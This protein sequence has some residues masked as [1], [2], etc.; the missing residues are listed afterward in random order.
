GFGARHR[1]LTVRQEK[2][3]Y[4]VKPENP[5]PAV[6]WVVESRDAEK[7]AKAIEPPIRSLNLLTGA[8]VRMEPVWG[9]AGSHKIVGYRFAEQQKAGKID[10]AYNGVLPNFSPCFVRVGDQIIFSSTVELAHTL[11]DE[12]EKESKSDAATNKSATVRSQ[13]FWEG[14]SS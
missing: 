12:L 11:V 9:M 7:F 8:L 6:A 5:I 13:F 10:T 4:R 1:L 14:L 2:R 3:G